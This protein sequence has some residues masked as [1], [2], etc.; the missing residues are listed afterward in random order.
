MLAAQYP[1]YT[2]TYINL[3]MSPQAQAAIVPNSSTNVMAVSCY[4]TVGGQFIDVGINSEI[5]TANTFTVPSD[6]LDRWKL[7]ETSGT[8]ASDS[9]SN[10]NNGTVHGATWN[11]RGKLGGCLNFNGFNNYVQVNREVSNDFSIAFWAQTTAAGATG[12]WRQG[13]GLVDG[14]V[15]SGANDFGVTLDGDQCAFGV[16]DPDTAIFSTTP[17]DDGQ[18]HYCV[19]TRTRST[20]AMQLYMDGFLEAT[21]A[22]GTNSLTSPAY[23]HFGSLQS[24]GGFFNGNLDDIRIYNRALGNL[25]ISALYADAATLP[26]APSNLTCV[27]ASQQAAL[28]WWSPHRLKLQWAARPPAVALTRS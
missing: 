22:G 5:L 26:S 4:Q 25:E 1:G 19:A 20:G 2:T 10:G 28:S 16:G 6:Y 27:V 8:V 7:D 15:G 12:S 18:W 9:T 14:S 17:I 11:P 24:D 23:L 3:P 13:S 21:G